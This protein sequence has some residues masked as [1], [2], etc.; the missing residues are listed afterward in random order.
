MSHNA[1]NKQCWP[2]LN[3][4]SY[5]KDARDNGESKEEGPS[6]LVTKDAAHAQH[7]GQEDGDGDNQLIDSSNL[8]DRTNMVKYSENLSTRHPGSGEI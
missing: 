2:P 1:T 6:G 8:K 7:L 3:R 5:L 4:F